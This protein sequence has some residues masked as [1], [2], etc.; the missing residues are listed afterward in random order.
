MTFGLKF[1]DASY[2]WDLNLFFR[3]LLGI[4]VKAYIDVIVVKLVGL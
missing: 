3:D 2:Q 4:I 1:V